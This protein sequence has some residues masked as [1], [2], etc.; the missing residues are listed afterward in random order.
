MSRINPIVHKMIKMCS[1]SDIQSLWKPQRG[2][3]YIISI[4]SYGTSKFKDQI[5]EYPD[6]VLLFERFEKD[7][8][9]GRYRGGN[10]DIRDVRYA[11]WIPSLDNLFAIA[12]SPCDRDYLIKGMRNGNNRTV[13]SAIIQ[14]IEYLMLSRFSRV[15][16][17]DRWRYA[18]A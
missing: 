15:W 1:C 5:R 3:R 16:D 11:C 13:E 14:F 7:N 2:D 18:D 8:I 6:S 4:D 9:K 17:N 10:G 12:E